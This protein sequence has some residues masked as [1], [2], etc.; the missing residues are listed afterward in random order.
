[1][2]NDHFLVLA[3]RGVQA[4]LVEEHFAE[5]RPLIPGLLRHVVVNLAPEIRI[6]GRLVEAGEFLVQLDAKNFVFHVVAPEIYLTAHSRDSAACRWLGD[7]RGV[8]H[9]VPMGVYI[10]SRYAA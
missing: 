7:Q 10:A 1:M 5:L 6:K 3:T 4:V 9:P 8:G 2:A